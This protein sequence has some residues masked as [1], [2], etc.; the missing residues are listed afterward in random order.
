MIKK[1]EEE[2]LFQKALNK[3]ETIKQRRSNINT[4]S[5]LSPNKALSDGSKN[6]RSVELES[7]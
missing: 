1:E 7:K 3:L 4:K 5:K 2:R 6:R